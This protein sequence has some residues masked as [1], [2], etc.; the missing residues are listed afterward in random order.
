MTPRG[1]PKKNDG[2]LAGSHEKAKFPG[3]RLSL[4]IE[5]AT[6]LR[7]V[8]EECILNS[9]VEHLLREVL[10]IA[11]KEFHNSIIDLIKRKRLSV[12]SELEKLVEVELRILTLWQK[13]TDMPKATKLGSAP[14]GE[15]NNEDSGSNRGC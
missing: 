12:E 15:R 7:K 10:G 6:N 3:F 9:K 14:L 4:E 13:K 2:S 11:K 1:K 5:K 8:L